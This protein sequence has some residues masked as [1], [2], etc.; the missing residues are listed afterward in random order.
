MSPTDRLRRPGIGRAG[1]RWG[2]RF[3]GAMAYAL[4][5]TLRARILFPEREVSRTAGRSGR[6]YSVWH[7][8][9]LYPAFFRRKLRAL[10]LVS[11]SRDGEILAGALQAL[12][13]RT[14]RGSTSRG[15][16]PALR[17]LL[18]SLQEGEDVAIAS[19][20]PRGPALRVQPGIIHLAS[21][22]GAP[23]IPIVFGAARAKTFAS[24]DRFCL[25]YPFARV[26][27]VFGR[28]LTV[29]READGLLLEAKRLELET[30]MLWALEAADA[31]AKG[32]PLPPVPAR[33][34]EE[35]RSDAR[36]GNS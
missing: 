13:Y 9:M 30:E 3:I 26:A 21:R 29:P 15:G 4:A 34:A 16:P 18:K 24:W 1:A 22:S 5:A 6:I 19:D 12:G 27:L 14:A 8:R 2:G 36:Y 17:R 7:G 11:L 10:V 33:D 23:V 35:A 20:G 28:P 25:P 32:K 31:A